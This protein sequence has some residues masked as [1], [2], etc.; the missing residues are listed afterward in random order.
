MSDKLKITEEALRE[1]LRPDSKIEGGLL[2]EEMRDR[3]G[4]LC[5]ELFVWLLDHT[6]GPREAYSVLHFTTNA[7]GKMHGIRGAFTLA[8]ADD[9]MRHAKVD[10][11]QA[12][13]S[14]K[15]E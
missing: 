13:Y 5:F 15:P 10:S 9:Q 7:L 3:L 6:S 8:V 4:E 2:T 1:A 14:K 12:Y 11:T